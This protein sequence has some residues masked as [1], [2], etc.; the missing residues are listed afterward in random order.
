VPVEN[1]GPNP[2]ITLPT[3]IQTYI[4]RGT[5]LTFRSTRVQ[6]PENFLS[7]GGTNKSLTDPDLVTSYDIIVIRGNLELNNDN[8]N[9]PIGLLV[10]VDGIVIVLGNITWN[11]NKSSITNSGILVVT[12]NVTPASGANPQNT[13]TKN[14]NGVFFVYQTS[15]DPINIPLSNVSPDF[16]FNIGNTRS[17]LNAVVDDIT[18]QL[19]VSSVEFPGI[20]RTILNY[21]CDLVRTGGS[22]PLPVELLAFEASSAGAEVL[23]NWSTATETNNDFFTLERSSDGINFEV[24]GRVGGK[25]TVKSTSEYRFTDRNPV[26]GTAF[27]RLSQTDYDGTTEVLGTRAVHFSPG[28][29]G[30][31]LY[32]NPLAGDQLSLR[33]SGLE[34]GKVVTFRVSDIAG[35]QVFSA[36]FTPEQEYLSRELDLNGSL[37]AG[38]YMVEL[39]QGNQRYTEKL[40]VP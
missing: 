22:F 1:A 12:G 35:R 16:D 20:S 24:I 29:S 40:I 7:V 15:P 17:N 32:P 25:C 26:L 27:Y 3:R 23:L 11:N 31:S 39:R 28:Q 5:T 37:R 6:D 38:L 4:D 14:E 33:A 13:I 30:L 8:A 18:T 19:C 21:I 36:D 10:D 9:K 34:K 2:G